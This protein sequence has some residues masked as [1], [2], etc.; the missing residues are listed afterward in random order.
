[1]QE[2]SLLPSVIQGIHTSVISL[3]DQQVV[4]L[5]E[6][7]ALAKVPDKTMDFWEYLYSWGGKWMW[8]GK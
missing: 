2:E 8:E 5:S 7:P 4:K 6:G 3:S 1:M